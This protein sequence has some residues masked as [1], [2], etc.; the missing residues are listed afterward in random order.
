MYNLILAGVLGAVVF[1]LVGAG[2]SPWAAIVPALLVSTGAVFLLTRRTGKQVEA[3]LAPLGPMLQSGQIEEARALLH[4]VRADWG[5]WQLL[6]DGSIAAQLGMIDYLQMKWDAAMPN[7]VAGRFRN[8]VAM[9]AIGCIHHRQG[10]K[11]EAWK[12]FEAAAAAQPKEAI[13]Y[14]VWATLAVRSNER[15]VALKAVG[16]GL[17]AMPDSEMLKQL[18][19]TIANKKKIDTRRFPE[20]WYQFFPEELVQQHLMRGRRDGALP[21]QQKQQQPKFSAK[22]AFR[23]R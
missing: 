6:L 12:E 2:L 18:Q 17:E 9:T 10:R 13:L 16:K 1:V 3:V 5:R 8:W 22:A 20:S 23:A 4:R 7:L 19:A 11:D 15:E 14:A 21:M